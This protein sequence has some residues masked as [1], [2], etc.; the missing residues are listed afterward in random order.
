MT[1]QHKQHVFLL[2]RPPEQKTARARMQLQLRRC[3][4]FLQGKQQRLG[5]VLMLYL[6]I[7]SIPLLFGQSLITVFALLP[8]LVVPPVGWLIYWLVWREFHG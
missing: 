3:W 8:L 4:A 2:N 5:V 6:A 7:W 1:F